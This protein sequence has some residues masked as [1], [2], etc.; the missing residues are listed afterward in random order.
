M[1][2]LSGK[3]LQSFVKKKIRGGKRVFQIIE[4]W[5]ESASSVSLDLERLRQYQYVHERVV[6]PWDV[7]VGSKISPPKRFRDEIILGLLKRYEHWDAQLQKLGEPYYLKVWLFDK[8]FF[9]SQIVVAIR[10]RIQWYENIFSHADRKLVFPFQHFANNAVKS[11]V[12]QWMPAFDDGSP[13]DVDY[14]Q[15]NL[16]WIGAVNRH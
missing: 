5:R 1:L 10:E 12:F 11:P 8:T 4:N 14:P 9:E 15:R 13:D 3:S 7:Y 16:V 2:R 6:H